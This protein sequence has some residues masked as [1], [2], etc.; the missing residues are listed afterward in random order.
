MLLRPASTRFS[1]RNIEFAIPC[2]WQPGCNNQVMSTGGAS[3]TNRSDDAIRQDVMFELEWEPALAH[4]DIAVAVKDGVVTL[5]GSV[6]NLW[7]KIEAERAAKRVYGVR[8]VAN[9]I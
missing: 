8:A 4:S 9:D 6:P 5:A 1:W 7:T 3:I 2:Q